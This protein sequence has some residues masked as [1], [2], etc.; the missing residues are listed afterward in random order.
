M[1]VDRN[2]IETNE[3]QLG[4]SIQK[5]EK[6]SLEMKHQYVSYETDL[7]SPQSQKDLS[8]EN[9]QKTLNE[10]SRD[11]LRNSQEEQMRSICPELE[12]SCERICTKCL[13]LE[14][15]LA[16]G[17]SK[18]T[19]TTQREC[20]QLQT[21][22]VE[23]RKKLE[24]VQL[25]YTL[26]MCQFSE[27]SVD[28]KCFSSPI[29]TARA[30]NVL[31][32]KYDGLEQMWQS[33]Q[34][35]IQSMATDYNLHQKYQKLQQEYEDLRRTSSASEEQV[36]QL[37][38]DNNRLQVEIVTLRER[39][40]EAQRQILEAPKTEAQ[41]DALKEELADVQTIFWRMSREY[42]EMYNHLGKSV[43]KCDVLQNE[44]DALC[45]EIKELNKRCMSMEVKQVELQSKASQKQLLLERQ[46]EK[47]ADD[48]QRIDQL[49]ETN[50]KLVERSTKAEESL[51]NN[52]DIQTVEEDLK[53]A[54]DRIETLEQTLKRDRDR[55]KTLEETLKNARYAV[56]AIEQIKTDELN[57]LKLEYL[58]KIEQLRNRLTSKNRRLEEC[59]KLRAELR[60]TSYLQKTQLC[61]LQAKVEHNSQL[62]AQLQC[63]QAERD[64]FRD[65]LDQKKESLAETNRKC[66]KMRQEIE[67]SQKQVAQLMEKN[68][69]YEK[70]FTLEEAN[71]KLNEL[72]VKTNTAELTSDTVKEVVESTSTT[73]PDRK[74]TRIESDRR[75]NRRRAVHDERRA[76][77]FNGML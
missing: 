42:D 53:S 19:E 4:Q 11:V 57:A 46:A 59:G 6:E 63:V 8:I 21:D 40:E 73:P 14:R 55:I 15:L 16:D 29:S 50:A 71:Q 45:T 2:Q 52:G 64:S 20:D 1:V 31:Q 38:A 67:E 30:D 51:Q 72:G 47:L 28:C 75:R 18:C 10:L 13:E 60:N 17:K 39:V 25:A 68:A 43:Q 37:D 58:D 33:Q 49:Q 23:T 61:A 32:E 48:V 7:L 74:S 41:I 5:L 62:E 3:E 65:A 35:V 56:D 26:A 27:K 76:P 69:V 36:V 77:Y 54:R 66:R 24:D 44:R 70:K 12:S 34:K 22:I 9:L